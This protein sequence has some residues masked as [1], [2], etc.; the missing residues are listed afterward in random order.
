MRIQKINDTL[1]IDNSLSN[2]EEIDIFESIE[3]HGGEFKIYGNGVPYLVF[4]NGLYKFEDKYFDSLINCESIILD[5][6]TNE[7]RG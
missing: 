5:K 1:K 3:Y 2:Q 6:I 7:S 4:D